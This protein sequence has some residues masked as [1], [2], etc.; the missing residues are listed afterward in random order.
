MDNNS[1]LLFEIAAIMIAAGLAAILFSKFRAPVIIGYIFA[2]ILLSNEVLSPIWSIE[3]ETI[4]FL[5]NLGII[6]LMFSIGIEFNLKRLKEIGGFAI[7]AGSIEVVI[8]IVVGYERHRGLR[9]IGQ[10]ADGFSASAS[11]TV[12][13]R[14]PVAQSGPHDDHGHAERVPARQSRRRYHSLQ[15]RAEA[16]NQE[17]RCALMFLALAIRAGKR[18]QSIPLRSISQNACHITAMRVYSIS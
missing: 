11:R 17:K 6:L 7:L 4:N 18:S 10:K 3:I 13:A 12:S 8:M 1:I 5:A 16:M 15:P 14:P 9:A 2:G